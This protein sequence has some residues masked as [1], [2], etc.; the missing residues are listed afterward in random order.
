MGGGALIS[1][2]VPRITAASALALARAGARPARTK[3]LPSVDI[4]GY[5]YASHVPK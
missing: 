2:G 3:L 1:A 4:R 5:K